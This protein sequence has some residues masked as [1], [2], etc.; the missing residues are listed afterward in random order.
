M[1]AFRTIGQAQAL[2]LEPLNRIFDERYAVYWK[3][4]E[5]SA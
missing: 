5:H 4:L 2:T 3:L 1:L